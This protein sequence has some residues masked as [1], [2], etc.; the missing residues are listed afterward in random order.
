LTNSP[1]SF[2]NLLPYE[3]FKGLYN[4]TLSILE[5]LPNLA[6]FK[7][8]NVLERGNWNNS[9]V[10]KYKTA[11]LYFGKKKDGTTYVSNL[12]ID[13][14]IKPLKTAVRNNVIPKLVGLSPMSEAGRSD[15]IVYSY[16]DFISN[17]KRIL[18][19]KT[20]NTDH[21]H[22]M[23]MQK[24]YTMENNKRVP[25]LHITEGKDGTIYTKYVYKA[26]NAWG[27]SFR[28]QEFYTTGQQSVLDNGFDKVANEVED[29]VIVDIYKGGGVTSTGAAAVTETVSD[30][31]DSSKKINIY[32]GTGEN[33]ELSNFANRPFSIE[34]PGIGPLKFN[35]V[36]GAFQAA[37][38][39]RTNSYLKTKK[40]TKEQ[41]ET[42]KQLT[43]STGAKAKSIGSSIKD[44]NVDE[45][46][47]ISSRT[48]KFLIK[49]SFE[50]NPDALNN[51]LATG[52]AELTHTQDKTK[53][54]TEFPRLLM[55]VRQE[56]RPTQPVSSEVKVD[57]S[58]L[59]DGDVVYDKLG[60]KFI[61]RGLRQAD[62]TGAGSPR[63]ER[64]DGTGEIAIP[65]ANIE[66]F[67]ASITKPDSISQEEDNT[68]TPIQ[69]INERLYDYGFTD[70]VIPSNYFEGPRP[71]GRLNSFKDSIKK[72][73]DNLQV[74]KDLNLNEFDFLSDNDKQRLDALR[75]KVEEFSK[76]NM[77][78]SSTERT[79]GKEK[80]Y[81]QLSNEILNEFVD[82]IGKHVEQQLGKTI[83]T[84]N[85]I[86][87]TKKEWDSLS[88][89]EKNKI[90]EC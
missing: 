30:V 90:N 11:T 74:L 26:I 83:E 14:L 1:I 63:L 36:E 58:T 20:G 38:I 47:S 72:V 60:T 70:L 49:A 6:E 2:T 4:E 19:R 56:L 54:G 87:I 43:T 62:Q 5:K 18:R 68:P 65:G 35:T 48:M 31:I 22:K 84:S 79:V 33:A 64:T 13:T 29:D 12:D 9:D 82:I 17:E 15:F 27:D 78:I 88:Q 59:K 69:G 37:K 21:Q 50:Q 28:A 61:F 66:L 85:P 7:K 55:E 75:S 24:V 86:G 16:E 42:I 3:D 23:L 51:L 40:L 76:L 81:A 52:N 73:A 67:K 71:A 39:G 57:N 8:V 34:V 25:L 44:L 45:W 32:A 46:N 89:E 53:W 10:S 41:E 80:R 77:T